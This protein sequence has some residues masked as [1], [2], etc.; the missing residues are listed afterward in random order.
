MTVRETGD[1][2]LFLRKIVRGGANKSFGIEVARLAGIPAVVTS[3]AKEILRRLEKNDIAR[4][5]AR[6][7]TEEPAW[8][9][10][11]AERILSEIDMNHLTPMQAFNILSDLVEKVRA[12]EQ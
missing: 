8:Q 11:E 6:A 4:D 1:G 7:V 12:K 5:A 3:R 2:I 10:S 9:Q